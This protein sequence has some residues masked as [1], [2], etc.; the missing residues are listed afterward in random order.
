MMTVRDFTRLLRRHWLLLL[1]VP[2]TTAASIYAFTRRQARSYTSDTVVYTGIASGYK[3]QGGNNDSGG[4]WTATATAF[5]NLLSLISARDTRQEVCLRLLAWRLMADAHPGTAD[6]PAR[7]AVAE[8][9]GW[10]GFGAKNPD[11]ESGYQQ[12][13]P[14]ALK[15]RLTG[16]TL[17]ETTKRV[18]AYYQAA[19][20]NE[21]HQLLSSKDPLYSEEALWRVTASRVKDSDLLR[22][23]YNAPDAVLC[24]KTLAILTDVFIRKHQELFTGQNGTVIGYFD[25]STQQAYQRLQAAERK[26]QDFHRQHNIVDYDKQIVSSTEE[27]QLAQDKYSQLQMQYAGVA[28]SLRSVEGTLNKRGASNLKSQEII[29]LR[30]RLADVNRQMSETELLSQAQPGGSTTARLDNL[31]REAADLSGRLDATVDS[32]Y[33]GTRSAQ[34]VAAKDLLTDYSKNEQLAADLRGQMELMRQH[35]DAAAAEYAALVP[36]G[37]EIRRI[38]RE[39]EV[40]EKEYL[41]QMEGLKQSKLSE[42]N[43]VLASQLRVVDPPYLPLKANGSKTLLLMLGGFLGT[44]LVLGAGLVTTSMLDRRLRQPALATRLTR[45]PVAGVLARRGGLSGQQQLDAQRAAEL[46]GRQLLLKFQQQHQPDKPYLIGVL[47]SQAGEGK[48]S[49]CASLAESLEQMRI[50]TLT[51]LPNDHADR[52]DADKSTRFYSPLL[53]VAPGATVDDFAGRTVPA[54]TVVIVEFPALL[55]AAYPAALLQELD[56]ILVTARADRAWHPA[57]RTVFD[58]IRRVTDAPIELVL[59]GV[60]PEYVADF[61]GR[62]ARPLNPQY[63]PALPGRR[64][65]ALLPGTA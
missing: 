44:F 46:L 55:E 45:L 17:A 43:G 31:K 11:A 54:G 23:E 15:A 61:I 60:L 59:N 40:A 1:L 27:R 30:N 29:R 47:S 22:V 13:L 53:G 19:P 14:P 24:Q 32:Y 33:A 38:R 18:M 34:G 26:L 4:D 7:P 62:Q 49:V 50:R 48:T 52:H 6:Y 20:G 35:R 51:L 3:I 5:D 41:S 37:G 21:L 65:Q 63:T 8:S 36:L 9:G 16:P 58:N 39:V 12:L 25:T 42:Q 10:L 57:D 64:P 28:G 56:L 2:L